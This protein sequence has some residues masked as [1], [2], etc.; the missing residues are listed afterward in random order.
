MPLK[1][2]LEESRA[3]EPAAAAIF[4]EA[5][6][7]AAAELDLRSVADRE[8]V[9]KIIMRLAHAQRSLDAAKIRDQAIIEVRKESR[10]RRRRP[11]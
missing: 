11:F 6:H 2:L 7:A 8:R 1:R 9:A 4:I 3:F 10:T 5:V